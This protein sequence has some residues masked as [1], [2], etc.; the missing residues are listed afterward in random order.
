MAEYQWVHSQMNQ[1][2]RDIFFS[3]FLY[4]ELRTIFIC[5]RHLLDKKAGAIDDLLDR[6]LL[7][8]EVK[9]VLLFSTDLPAA[10]RG[11]ERLFSSLSGRFLGLGTTLESSGLRAVEQRLIGTYSVCN[12]RIRSPS[13]PEDVLFPADRCAEH[14]GAV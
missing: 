8:D 2:L 9:K 11:I 10:V 14:S 6:S 5:L 7:S 3:F 13:A 1:Q 12:D 4:A